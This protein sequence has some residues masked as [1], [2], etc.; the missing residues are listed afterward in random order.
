MSSNHVTEGF[1]YGIS[2]HTWEDLATGLPC[3]QSHGLWREA[4]GSTEGKCPLA[5]VSGQMKAC[6][7][8]NIHI[9]RKLAQSHK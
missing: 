5:L 2:Q 4:A 9:N 3:K 7:C 1:R 8:Q 6:I